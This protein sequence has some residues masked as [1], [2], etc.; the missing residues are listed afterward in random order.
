MNS[1]NPSI[2]NK[3][4]IKAHQFRN[5]NMR[6]LQGVKFISLIALFSIKNCT[7]FQAYGRPNVVLAVIER[8]LNSRYHCSN[9]DMPVQHGPC[10]LSKYDKKEIKLI[11]K[12][13]SQSIRYLCNTRIKIQIYLDG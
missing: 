1:V 9:V 2:K 11:M 12:W 4:E 13:H 10:V 3:S 8:K 7:A 5:L 6:C